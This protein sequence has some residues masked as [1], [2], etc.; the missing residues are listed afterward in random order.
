MKLFP[1]LFWSFLSILLLLSLVFFIFTYR[2]V[3]KNYL[4]NSLHYLQEFE[5]I[6]GAQ[7]TSYLSSSDIK[8]LNEFANN[9]SGIRIS[10]INEAGK[11]IADSDKD[12]E[13]L[14]NHYNRPEII[15]AREKGSG[16]SWRY[17]S[18]VKHKMLY[19]AKK[20]DIPGQVSGYLRL[21]FYDYQIEELQSALLKDLTQ[22]IFIGI[23]ASLLITYLLSRKFINPIKKL[24][25]ATRKVSAGDFS[26]RL[27][28]T[29][30]DELQELSVSFNSMTEQVQKLIEESDSRKEAL[31]N[32][33]DNIN[34]LLWVIEAETEKITLANKAFSSFLGIKDPTDK[35]YWQQIRHLEINEIIKETI[36]TKQSVMREIKLMEHDFLMSVSYLTETD[37]IIFLLHDIT[38]LRELEKVKRDFVINASHELRTPLASIKGYTELLRESIIPENRNLLEII[39]RNIFRLSFL[40]NDILTLASLEDISQL[41]RENTNVSQLLDSACLLFQPKLEVKGLKLE[42]NYDVNI[43]AKIDPFRFEQ[44]V[45]NLI[46]NAIK[47]TQSGKISLLLKLEKRNLIF[48]CRDT[49]IG[50]PADALSRIFE[51]FFVVDKSRSRKSGGT[52]LGLSIVKH[53]VQLHLGT[54]SVKSSPG[55]GSIFHV[56]IPLPK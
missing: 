24:A 54:I 56:E 46:D 50:I 42:K 43:T 6:I 44:L 14:G 52:G 40:V 45:N 4:D 37:L 27:I 19:Y 18:S 31:S 47:Y 26:I 30:H 10:F 25:A 39:E 11:V 49:G 17:S 8:G 5:K 23:L 21:S 3:H 22:V 9:Q 41:D 34:E 29:S 1:K 32:I 53:I 38:P 13:S 51:R 35:L 7:V 48:E 2:N 36:S 28:P 33:I 15:Q 12:L 20:I 55:E 16:F